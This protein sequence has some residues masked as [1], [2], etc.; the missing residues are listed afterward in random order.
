MHLLEHGHP[1]GA[2]DFAF[3]DHLRTHAEDTR[4][5]AR[6]KLEPASRFS[7]DRPAYVEAKEPF[8][9]ELLARIESA[10]G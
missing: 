9:R 4:A 7:T 5:Y 6:L 1:W 3:R 8:I 2:K 10:G